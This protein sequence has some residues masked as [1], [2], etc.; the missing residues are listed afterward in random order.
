MANDLEPSSRGHSRFNIVL[1]RL[2]ATIALIA[3]LALPLTL[4][5]STRKYPDRLPVRFWHMWSSEHRVIVDAIVDRFNESQN[6]Y[7]VIALS[8]P[9]SSADSKFLLAVAGGDPPDVMAQWNQVI[10]KWAESQLII[11]LDEVM[12][13]DEWNRVHDTTFPIALKIG[14]YNDHLYGVTVGLDLYACYYRLDYVRDSG[15]PT[16]HLPLTLEELVEWG[17]KLNRFDSHGRLTRAGFLWPSNPLLL[18][19]FGPAFGG[20]L[21][22]WEK[23]QLTIN[24]PENLQVLNF[25]MDAVKRVG[26]KKMLMFETGFL[27]QDSSASWPFVNGGCAIVVDGQW[28]VEQLARYAPDVEYAVTPI[29]PPKGG[30]ELAGW[31]N[32]NFMVIPAGATEVRGAWE[33]IK[34]WSGIENPE[35]AAEFYAMGGWLPSCE[36]VAEAPHYKEFIAKYPHF[37]GFLELLQSENLEPTP[38]VP[39]QMYLWD[40]VAQGESACRDGTLSPQASLSRMEHE[41]AVELANR[42]R[43]GYG[44]DVTIA[45]RNGR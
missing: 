14:T 6:T 27:A 16:D 24:T 32:G 39:F 36:R 20:G 34:F 11:P 17:E 2:I 41:L 15:L 25:V 4:G 22:D 12:S 35:R 33:F 10:P 42:K 37:T 13:E 28:R 18:T 21:Y 7:E 26:I 5:H 8:V 38:P 1:V 40:R 23:D 45:G 3:T 9:P 43:L 30:R 44:D 31:A 29:P 19:L